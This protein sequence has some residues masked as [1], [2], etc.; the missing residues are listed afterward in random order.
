MIK[1]NWKIINVSEYITLLKLQYSLI[2][3]SAVKCQ[4]Y[5]QRLY[6]GDLA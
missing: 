5:Y 2:V 4:T 1:F 3:E 6:F